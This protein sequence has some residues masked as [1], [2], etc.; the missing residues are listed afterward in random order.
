MSCDFCGMDSMDIRSLT[1]AYRSK[2]LSPVAVTAHYLEKIEKEQP[3]INAFITVCKDRAMEQAKAAEERYLRGCP[4]GALDGVPYAV[5][6][7][8][9]V[10]G[11]PT[12]MGC[13]LYQNAI[14][15]QSAFAVRKLEDAGAVMLG[16]TNTSQFALGATG[17]VSAAGPCCN[18]YDPSRISGGS[19]SG[20]A[21]AVAAGLCRFALGTDTGGSVR[22]PAALCGVYSIRP[23]IG[24]VSGNGMLMNCQMLDT[25]GVMTDN[26]QDNAL[27]L[28]AISGYDAD[29][30]LSYPDAKTNTCQDVAKGVQGLTLGVPISFFE[31]GVDSYVL[32]AIKQAVEF[33]RSIGVRILEIGMPDIQEYRPVMSKLLIAEAYSM[34]E[35]AL[36]EHR[37]CYDPELLQ[38][39]ADAQN[40][41]MTEYIRYRRSVFSFR[42][43]FQH[44]FDGV[45]AVLLPTQ[46]TVAVKR[47]SDPEMVMNGTAANLYEI[48]SRYL[49]FTA[50]AGTAAMNV[51]C[52]FHEG[53]PLGMQLLAPKEQEGILY[54]FAYQYQN[55]EMLK[56][57]GSGGCLR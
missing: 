34:H 51:P 30:A 4:I 31:N 18:P 33:Y 12:T 20:S 26:V 47:N 41:E 2:R 48:S 11:V 24:R 39:F 45:D 36:N 42:K 3:R 56:N 25:I 57:N 9:D 38:R 17:E 15:A 53:L 44:L 49:W 55:A 16:K 29:Y 23:T 13:R 32:D 43:K 37:D 50:L 22:A 52:G 14:A 46:A 7:I 27:V 6:D 21:A 8:I 40:L 19:S 1:A 54:R 10:Q 5:K 28:D 35:Q